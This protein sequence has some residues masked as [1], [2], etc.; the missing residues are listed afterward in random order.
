MLPAVAQG[1]IGVESRLADAVINKL[2]AALDDAPSRV[3]V[4]AERAFLARLEGSC[5]TPIAGYARL[6]SGRFVFDGEILT[7]DGSR[8]LTARREGT[9]AEANALAVSAADE[10]LRQA[11]PDFFAGVA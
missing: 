3:A 4:D 2:L 5:R 9:P 8:S 1:A 6:E 7:V 11:G 10:L